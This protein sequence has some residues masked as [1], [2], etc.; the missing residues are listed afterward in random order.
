MP[1]GKI[2]ST[3]CTFSVGTCIL[4]ALPFLTFS[5][6]TSDSTKLKSTLSFMKFNIFS[7]SYEF[8]LLM[9]SSVVGCS[10][11][12]GGIVGA[13]LCVGGFIVGWLSGDGGGVKGCV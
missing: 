2:A 6:C 9:N 11:G 13:A 7:R 3:A 4:N 10:K 5:G 12:V 1:S 8:I